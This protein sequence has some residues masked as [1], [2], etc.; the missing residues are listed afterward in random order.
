MTHLPVLAAREP[1]P[2]AQPWIGPNGQRMERLELHLTYT[3]PERCS[4]CSEEHRMQAYRR[5]P[6]T[7]GRVAT[8][9]RRQAE[10]GVS[11]LHITGGEP[12]I[13]PRFV[14][15][16][17]LAKK[18][19]M[20]TSVGTIGTRLADEAF[21]R[22][23]LPHLDEA[24]FSLHGPN[25]A[26]HDELA[27]REGSFEQVCRALALARRIRPAFNAFVNTVITRKN[28]ELLGDTVA[29]ADRLGAKLIVIS[30]MTPEGLGLDNYEA[31]SVPL[32]TLARVLPTIPP[33]AHEAI[34]RFFGT[35]MCLLGEHAMLSN[36][37]HW[38]PRVTVEWQSAPGKVMFDGIYS[39]SPDRRRVHT[40]ECRDCAMNTVCMGVF[41]RYAELYP[42][43]ALKPTARP[44]DGEPG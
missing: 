2:E 11:N 20:R 12:T 36:D 27:G 23:A 41:D 32:D 16:L 34:V 9:L 40:S 15:V 28:I 33:R 10:R 35:P 19:G 17:R 31:L 3:C 4:F 43:T 38:D 8:V 42:T 13:H 25:A 30:N 14:D 7:F 37:L 21:A 18:L 1:D 24:L 44:F 39:W 6:V 22:D 26:V 29:L 5:F